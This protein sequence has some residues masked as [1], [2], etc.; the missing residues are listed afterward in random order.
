MVRNREKSSFNLTMRPPYMPGCLEI[1]H[2]TLHPIPYM[3]PS[4]LYGPEA[5]DA[6]TADQN[7]AL[8]EE[9]Q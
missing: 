9:Q 4:F 5:L 7:G 8:H 3:T 6:C 2:I 1:G